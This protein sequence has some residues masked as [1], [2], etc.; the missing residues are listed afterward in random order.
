[1]STILISNNPANTSKNVFP[2]QGKRFSRVYRPAS[3]SSKVCR[4]FVLA[5]NTITKLT[6][7]GGTLTRVGSASISNLAVGTITANPDTAKTE[8]TVPDSAFAYIYDFTISDAYDYGYIMW[9]DVL[10]I[11]WGLSVGQAQLDWSLGKQDTYSNQSG[12]FMRSP[13][14]NLDISEMNM[15]GVTNVSHLLNGATIFNQNIDALDFSSVTSVVSMIANTT[16]F[17]QPLNCLKN[18]K[19]AAWDGFAQN[20]IAFNQPITFDV[21]NASNWSG[22]FS[23]ASSFNQPVGQLDSS[24]CITLARFLQNARSFNQTVSTLNVSKVI[25]VASMFSGASS[26]NQDI[27]SFFANFPINVAMDGFI[28]NTAISTTNYDKLL[29][30]FWLDYNTT[31][32][33]AWATRTT[34]KVFGAAGVKHTSAAATAKAGLVSA[35]WTITDGGLA[36]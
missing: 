22:I 9:T 2:Q 11:G 7:I 21:T 36:A 1:M 32:A 31:R 15:T 34:P 6:A 16:K 14:F 3:S 18:A 20:A 8:V 30:A 33:S 5:T 26:F 19:I 10:S 25:S 13:E 4:F 12:K 17:N 28:D 23:G 35:G 27:S 24:N 29:N